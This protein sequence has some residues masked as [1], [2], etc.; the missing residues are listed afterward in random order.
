MHD[1]MDD[2]SEAGRFRRADDNVIVQDRF[3]P[4]ITLHV[5]PPAHE[6]P[7]RMQALCDFANASND[8][9]FLHPVV[10]A[11]AI[12]FQMGYDHPFCDGNGRTARALFYWSMLRS[13]YWL[14]EYI[15]ISSVLKK[16]PGQYVTS[17]LYTESDDS[18]IGY[19]V[20]HQLSVIE[21]A[22]NGFRSYMARKVKERK[23]AE[24]LLRPGSPLG[25]QLNHRQR[26]LLL[27]AI[28]HMDSIYE[29]AGHQAAHRI[30]YPTARNDL[31]GLEALQLLTKKKLGK[32]FVFFPVSNLADMLKSDPWK[33]E[34]SDGR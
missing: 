17:Y 12:H 7:E 6:L 20:A 8:E 29:I 28:R 15:S 23:Q 11:I 3:D 9:N 30:A 26:A 31:L 22:I 5:P 10:R 27:H 32:G 18:D 24:A 14:S 13:G 33:I 25:A 19:F 16:A 34:E 1:A 4:T 2:P 21:E